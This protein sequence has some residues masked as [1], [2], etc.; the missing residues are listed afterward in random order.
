MNHSDMHI[1]GYTVHGQIGHGGMASVY[2]A[3]QESLNR[4]VAIKVLRNSAEQGI[5]ERFVKEAHF[6]ASLS[7]PHVITIYDISTLANGDHYIAMEYV[8]GGDLTDNQHR[9]QQPDAA[10]RL[11]RQIADG[12]AVVHDKGIIH[13]DVKPANILFRKDGS[14][15]LTDFGIAKDVDNNS[16]LTQAGF[17]LG[18]PSYSSPEQ[19]QGQPLDITT[20]IYGL[21]VILLE[22]LLGYN[23]FKGDSHTSTAINHIQQPVPAL[24][25]K[26][27][28]LSPL[29][30]RMLAKQSSTRFQSCRELADAIEPLLEP[31][32][33]R[34]VGQKTAPIVSRLGSIRLGDKTYPLLL[35]ALGL[36]AAVALVFALTYESE[37]DRQIRQLLEQAELSLDE[38]RYIFPEHDN[39]RY[40]YR[41]VLLLDTD[42]RT[43]TDG[44][45]TVTQKLIEDYVARG[46]E[47]L[48]N[49]RLNRP[50]GDNA[51][52]YYRKALALDTE[53][54]QANAG[55]EQLAAEFTQ[56]ARAD[57]LVEDLKGADYNVVRGLRI[58]P[59]NEELLAL[60][61]EIDQK[62]PAA[63]KLIRNV[64]G[65][66]RESI[67][68]KK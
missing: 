19:A 37:T 50:K 43:A 60:R 52:H 20:D 68:G 8:D 66:I 5:S 7:N 15:V 26:L 27:Q 25:A 6:I 58:Q 18:S 9:F 46:A 17:S 32:A 38:G 54:P 34:A 65:K 53:S 28:Y 13:R 2:L 62:M 45:E 35:P 64:F 51:L 21:G 1:P 49:G 61:T 3:T 23:P 10:L 39:A 63:K 14:A 16:D 55:M 12:L 42:N 40:Y 67:D 11:I 30:A 41:Q 33:K 48:E 22:L 31:T 29:L 24:P 44:L 56:R 47:A 59:E 57:L 4:K 36:V